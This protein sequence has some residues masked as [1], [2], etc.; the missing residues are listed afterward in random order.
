MLIGPNAPIVFESKLR[1]SHMAHVY[2]FYKPNLASEYPVVDCKLSQTCYLMAL[3]SCY[4]H[5]CNKFEKLEAKE[6]SINDVDYFVFHSPYNKEYIVRLLMD[7]WYH[8]SSITT[9]T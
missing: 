7:R 6:F 2:D 4:K 9:C 5:L 1:G 3:D 8:I